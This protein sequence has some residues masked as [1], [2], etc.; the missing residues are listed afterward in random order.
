ML[1]KFGLPFI[2]GFLKP[3]ATRYWKKF[4]VLCFTRIYVGVQRPLQRH[5]V[6]RNW[7]QWWFYK[8]PKALHKKDA[9]S[10]VSNGSSEFLTLLSTKRGNSESYQNFESRLAAGVSKLNSHA[11]NT[12]PESFIALKLLAYRGINANQ[13]ISILA[14]ATPQVTTVMNNMTDQQLSDS[15]EYG[16]IA[17]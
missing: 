15:V 4:A 8:F 16:P 3:I 1:S 11:W 14:A 12:L 7:V 9:L 6:L 5:S 17:S 13:C 10:V 2:I